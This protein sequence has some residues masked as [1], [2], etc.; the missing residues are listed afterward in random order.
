[1]NHLQERLREDLEL[2]GIIV[3]TE[4][5]DVLGIE[6]SLVEKLL[7]LEPGVRRGK[8]GRYMSLIAF[9]RWLLN[10]FKEDGFVEVSEANQTWGLS[11]TELA[12]LL[13]QYA[14]KTTMTKSGDYLSLSWARQK[15]YTALKSGSRVKPDQ[16]AQDLNVDLG[17]AEAIMS[18][19]DADAIYDMEGSMVPISEIRDLVVDTLKQKGMLDPQSYAE[20]HR[21]DI[22]DFHRITEEL[23]IDILESKSGKIISLDKVV[24][25]VKNGLSSEG[26]YDIQEFSRKFK[27]D[28]ED[29][30]QRIESHLD[31]DEIIVD[32]A[33]LIVNSKWISQMKTDAEDQGAL[34]IT[35]FAREKGLRRASVIAL[36]RRFLKGAYIPRSDSFLLAEE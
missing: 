25:I 24:E 9:R 35:T 8:R 4:E 21:I 29:V 11:H 14:V 6:S 13:K 18:H 23:E 27:I 12:L 33:G 3:P 30:V 20:T 31:D 7:S 36:A 19:V 15:V 1:V 28:Y 22:S 10:E 26:L 2:I 16:L 5:A 34:R 32:T 17:I